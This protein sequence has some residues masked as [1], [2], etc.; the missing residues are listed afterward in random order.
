MEAKLK[1]P[2]YGLLIA[3]DDQMR[4]NLLLGHKK[5]SIREGHRDYHPGQM[6]I[7]DQETSFVVMVDLVN[8]KHTTLG[9]V[10]EEE[11]LA[12]GF[13]SQEDMLEGMKIFY[14]NINLD[15]PVTVLFWENV[16]GIWTTP[17][18]IESFEN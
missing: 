8:V 1:N 10:T 12:D 6:L 17:E 18:A 13:T 16:R 7:G 9:E 11:W 2:L 15:S 3:D 4:L 14:P 5:I